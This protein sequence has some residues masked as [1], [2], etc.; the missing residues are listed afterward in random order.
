MSKFHILFRSMNV[1]EVPT[2]KGLQARDK[3]S[4]NSGAEVPLGFQHLRNCSLV[5][6]QK[7]KTVCIWEHTV[8]VK[9]L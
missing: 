7:K 5:T 6:D 9:L 8:E 4:F 2:E 1:S 3:K